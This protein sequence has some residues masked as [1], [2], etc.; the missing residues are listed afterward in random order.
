MIRAE[1]A[2]A[3]AIL[4]CAQ[5]AAADAAAI[6]SGVSGFSLMRR[7]GEA[8][9]RSVPDLPGEGPVHILCGPGKNGGDGLVAACVLA[10]GGIDVR[11][12][13]EGGQEA[14]QGDAARARSLWSGPVSELSRA[15]PPPGARVIDALYGAGLARPL[16]GAAARL[17]DL[18][19][20]W[21]V[22]AVD[23]P[24]GLPGDTG[25]PPGPVF[26]ATRTLT[27]ERL[28]PAHVLEPGRSLCGEISLAAI[29]FPAGTVD[30][31]LPETFHNHPD[32]WRGLFPWPGRDI[33]KHRRGR[34]SVVSGPVHATGAARLAARAGL[35]MGAGLVRLRCR[36]GALLVNALSTMAVMTSPFRSA[37]ELTALC[38]QDRAVVIGPAAGVTPETREAVIGLLGLG[39]HLVLDADAISVFADAPEA[40]FGC[41]RPDDVLTPHTAEFSRLFGD[42]A[43]RAA[44]K[45]EAVREA[46]RRAGCVVLLKGPDT[47][48]AAPDGRVVVNTHASPFLATAGSGDVLA[49][50]IGG[51][52]AQGMA[53]FE[54][55]CTAVWLH[56]E[57]GLRLGPG[58]IAEDLTEAL[59]AVL[60]D[61]HAGRF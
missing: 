33:H 54:A 12:C 61:L 35:R 25:R 23:L 20:G 31:V 32:L 53:S 56:G 55:A 16:Q 29:G 5:M 42:L 44:S 6:R 7:A 48:I 11:V 17:A 46:A 21:H 14:A 59:P 50:M 3:H 43:E 41:L 19:R 2:S 13:L 58:L 18:S 51:L 24:S 27:F 15:D 1:T 4:T 52:L 8:V 39:A 40:L 22:L 10:A 45:I 30:E 49:G 36:P 47:C 26:H 57:A 60:G 9:A 38:A 34:L 28:K 37:G